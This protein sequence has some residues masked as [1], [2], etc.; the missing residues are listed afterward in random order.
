MATHSSLLAWRIPWTE[1]PGRLQSIEVARVRHDLE[2][3]PPPQVILTYNTTCKLPSPRDPSHQGP[4]LYPH[5]PLLL[6][7][8]AA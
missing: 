7:T 8:Q 4:Q 3:K 1:E 2:T 6:R 5:C